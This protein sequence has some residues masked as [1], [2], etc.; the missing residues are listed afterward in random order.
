MI[1]EP[2][3]VADLTERIKASEEL[4]AAL[5]GFLA[6]VHLPADETDPATGQ[7]TKRGESGKFKH[8]LGNA[9][10]RKADA[11]YGAYCLKQDGEARNKSKLWN[12]TGPN[13]RGDAETRGDN[14]L[15]N[16]GKPPPPSLRVVIRG[17]GGVSEK[18]L[19]TVSAGLRV[20]ARGDLEEGEI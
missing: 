13:T 14:S 6:E 20:S 7:V 10:A 19:E 11:Y 3:T 12:V 18:E 5:P 8:R 2:L 16:E 1:K 17:G 4:R 15:V 9:L